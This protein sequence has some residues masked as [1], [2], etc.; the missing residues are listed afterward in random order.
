M[1]D[2]PDGSIQM[3]PQQ[4]IDAAGDKLGV[5]KWFREAIF[6]IES[7]GNV[8]V[9]NS[10]KGA[11]GIGQLMPGTAAQLGVDPKDPVQNIIGSLRLQKQLLNKY[12][13]N[14]KGDQVRGAILAAAAYNAGEGAVD[15]HG[16]VP[17]YEETQAYVQKMADAM[18]RAKARGELGKQTPSSGLFQKATPE[19]QEEIR[20][21]VSAFEK[22][23]PKKSTEVSR[24]RDAMAFNEANK[25]FDPKLL[26][27][28]PSL[29]PEVRLQQNLTALSAREKLAKGGMAIDVPTMQETPLPT[30][31]T[32]RQGLTDYFA[33]KSVAKDIGGAIKTTSQFGNAIVGM[34]PQLTQG[35]I[36]GVAST[37]GFLERKVGVGVQ[38]AS[39]LGSNLVLG[40]TGLSTPPQQPST[41]LF[42][43]AGGILQGGAAE[44]AKLNTPETW[45]QTVGRAF[46]TGLGTSLIELP[47]LVGTSGLGAANLAAHGVFNAYV[48]NPE[49]TGGMVR[50]ALGG[51]AYHYGGGFTGKYLGRFGNTLAWIGGPAVE[52]HL[53]NG[54]PLPQALAKAA[55]MGV[56]AGIGG[57]DR[58]HVIEEDG[59]VRP[60]TLRDLPGIANGTTR[61]AEP[62]QVVMHQA[63]EQVR[64][65]LQ[66][67]V[68]Q[69]Q[70]ADSMGTGI[71]FG[72]EPTRPYVFK[73]KEEVEEAKQ[74]IF[75]LNNHG[76]RRI[77]FATSS[78]QSIRNYF[79]QLD[80]FTEKYAPDARPLFNKAF[81]AWKQG[82]LQ[83]ATVASEEA[84]NKAHTW[85]NNAMRF[86][87]GLPQRGEATFTSDTEAINAKR[88]ELIDQIPR[89][90]GTKYVWKDGNGRTSETSSMELDPD[91]EAAKKRGPGLG[92]GSRVKGAIKKALGTELPQPQADLYARGEGPLQG[93]IRQL[94]PYVQDSLVTAGAHHY[95]AGNGAPEDWLGRMFQE[96][97]LATK[98]RRPAGWKEGPDTVEPRVLEQL[99]QVYARSK[100]VYD[101]GR[102]PTFISGLKQTVQE[103]RALNLIGEKINPDRLIN[104]LKQRG[105]EA[106]LKASG[107]GSALENWKKDHGNEPLTLDMVNTLLDTQGMTLD[108]LRGERPGRVQGFSEDRI[109]EVGAYDVPRT[110]GSSE[111]FNVL[112]SSEMRSRYVSPGSGEYFEG[113]VLSNKALPT[114]WS[115]DTV[116]FGQRPD[117]ISWYRATL[118]DPGQQ[119]PES[120]Q[121]VKDGNDGYYHLLSRGDQYRGGPY[122][123]EQEAIAAVNKLQAPM[124]LEATLE[125]V[126]SK[127]A[128]R[129][130]L[131]GVTIDPENV[132]SKILSLEQESARLD[133]EIQQLT[134]D[135]GIGRWEAISDHGR[136]IPEELLDEV[137]A[138]QEVFNAHAFGTATREKI[139]ELD[140][141]RAALNMNDAELNQLH[142][143]ADAAKIPWSPHLDSWHEPAIK[144]FLRE[145][146]ER[147]EP[148]AEGNQRVTWAGASEQLRR[149]PAA[150]DLL[151]RVQWQKNEPITE[152]QASNVPA[153]VP[154]WDL[155][156]WSMQDTGRGAREERTVGTWRTKGMTER[157]IEE[158]LGREAAQKIINDEYDTKNPATR[159]RE[160]DAKNLPSGGTWAVKLYG[161]TKENIQRLYPNMPDLLEYAW[162]VQGNKATVPSFLE[163]YGKALGGS[164][165]L[166]ERPEPYHEDDMGPEY[167]ANFEK[168]AAAAEKPVWPSF[169]LS[170]E[171]QQRILKEGQLM[172]GKSLPALPGE[173]KNPALYGIR[174]QITNKAAYEAS[175]ELTKRQLAGSLQ[176]WRNSEQVVGGL[177]IKA[178]S[179]ALDPRVTTDQEPH[180]SVG[181]V[182][183]DIAGDFVRNRWTAS[184]TRWFLS[185]EHPL[186]DS[187]QQRIEQAQ[188]AEHDFVISY[189]RRL[190][191]I[192]ELLKGS[193]DSEVTGNVATLRKGKLDKT[194]YEQA[195]TDFVH[196]LER[197]L[198][199]R[200]SSD[201]TGRAMKQNPLR[202]SGNP[203]I[204]KAL[205][206]HDALTQ[207]FKTYLMDSMEARGI[208]ID[209]RDNWG[210]TTKGYFRH[211][212]P[213]IHNIFLDGKL[214]QGAERGNMTNYIDAK[215]LANKLIEENPN[216]TVE[217]RK[218]PTK[219]LDSAVRISG[220]QYERTVHNLTGSLNK[221][222][223]QI[224]TS[225]EIRQDT[226]GI[227][228]KK[229]NLGK[230]FAATLHREGYEGFNTAYE[231]VMSTHLF[232]LVRTQELSKLKKDIQPMV[233]Q[234]T[235]EHVDGA[236]EGIDLLMNDLWGKPMGYEKAYGKLITRV[237]ALKNRTSNPDMLMESHARRLT[238]LINLLKLQLNPK[239]AF[240]NNIQP[241]RTMWPFL[242]TTEMAEVVKRMHDPAWKQEMTD[243]GVMKGAVK[244]E[245]GSSNIQ[246]FGLKEA[247]RPGGGGPFTYVS[248]L[249]RARGYT[250]GMIK[251][252]ALGLGGLEKHQMGLRWAKQV[253]F[254]NSK[255]DAPPFLKHPL[256]QVFGQYKGFLIKD[257]ENAIETWQGQTRWK[258]LLG[259]QD[260]PSQRVLRPVK[261]FAG[262]AVAGGL[263]AA[264]SP[265]S[266]FGTAAGYSMYL[267]TAARIQSATGVS[268]KDAKYYSSAIFLGA[269][270][271][272]GLDLSSSVTPLDEPQGWTPFDKIGRFVGGPTSTGILDISKAV[273]HVASPGQSDE[274]TVGER[275][276]GAAAKATPYARMAQ[277]FYQTEEMLRTGKKPTINLD[278]TEVQLTAAQTV[279]GMFGVPPASQTLYYEEKEAT[280]QSP[281]AGFPSKPFGS[282]PAQRPG[283]KA[284]KAIPHR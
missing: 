176:L 17:P 36:E 101:N 46:G 179:P 100:A 58:A 161:D 221:D 12:T 257:V 277:R 80:D 163:K 279:M 105:Q 146:V 234:L 26:P 56:F 85:T 123:T 92:F 86:G 35:F 142:Q 154:T 27:S 241:L 125:E 136:Y 20:K 219:F 260:T 98:D 282:T 156:L 186:M 62:E 269:P 18:R 152:E 227:I 40:Y 222:G 194:K 196:L 8:K 13:A 114:A 96:L 7:R 168:L 106:E 71:E 166:T 229:E 94:P 212:F 82:D 129:A 159:V 273:Y 236:V 171:M 84:L 30:Q 261:W 41:D 144:G 208:R 202:Q 97:T 91:Q 266:W 53:T 151:T 210:L 237:P 271:L 254:D 224:I 272:A 250:A 259:I 126:Q 169:V 74:R 66:R 164:I 6:N 215:I 268:D 232:Q 242:T 95:E 160:I 14:Q 59:S 68:E 45:T 134:T 249:N 115:M 139:M 284:F 148:D 65:Q 63:V 83:T 178:G 225:S 243:L 145:A 177:G 49:D 191:A 116:H 54:T 47:Q 228:G 200:D 110:P 199:V 79:A 108:V 205:E 2:T 276:I 278:G 4:L 28:A 60:A 158:T 89:T 245:T 42:T 255:W 72:S 93:K 165:E 204:Q 50:G 213:G 124:P 173:A 187:I 113:V 31:D 253:E 263:R 216:S 70:R 209:D 174:N 76:A 226:K 233:E 135:L 57:A 143:D 184:S 120:I 19:R 239:S 118:R 37:S 112:P 240:I 247:L 203:L 214:Y 16:G 15:T 201:P 11:M 149:Y 43:E 122:K 137:L 190:A 258:T 132:H 235:R 256:G 67:A 217:I 78:E 198:E 75:D 111:T 231:A 283:Q 61:V 189:T 275:A 128:S 121:V 9:G 162:K 3:T 52:D 211:L 81:D 248:G 5:P 25:P 33:R 64:K 207:D 107:L 218:R 109:N 38:A 77:G 265:F 133:S 281:F 267:M 147:L 280:G 99:G 182:I 88:W 172:F 262:T 150:R 246:R 175:Q 264:A 131:Q 180:R 29:D 22:G 238:G 195:Q 252:E 117:S 153:G 141:L 48:E 230:F 188:T 220:K 69:G 34:D 181:Q 167:E 223:E 102:A 170:P 244:L 103:A 130:R 192:N 104:I 44:A 127:R 55:P 274:R 157:G 193:V 73:S 23:V 24:L 183:S 270:A 21:G 251:A 185:F 119:L 90:S 206:E 51:L 155:T 10:P 140:R 138:N 32:V 87:A 197:D 39:S 1:P